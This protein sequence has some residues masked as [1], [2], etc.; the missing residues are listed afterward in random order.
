MYILSQHS[1]VFE[2]L[3]KLGRTTITIAHR[4]S[5]IKHAHR[6]FVINEG[7]LVE[8]GSHD[9]LM[10]AKGTYAALVAAQTLRD[11]EKALKSEKFD[12]S[13]AKRAVSFDL[14]LLN[15]ETD[16]SYS[17][18]PPSPVAGPEDYEGI[19]ARIYP[20][21]PA[22]GKPS[23]VEL[24]LLY[25]D[26][27][28]RPSYLIKRMATIEPEILKSY[29]IAGVFALCMILFLYQ[30]TS[31]MANVTVTGLVLPFFSII[32]GKFS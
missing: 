26:H 25:S 22:S 27:K 2:H 5:T 9:E 20:Q 4:L 18:E 12:L 32:F 28:Y 30:D 17:T 6:I 16:T 19:H 3:S 23:D 1:R 13:A 31:L 8:T 10:S 21:Q 7:S 11:Y 15:P 24:A 14:P 29:M